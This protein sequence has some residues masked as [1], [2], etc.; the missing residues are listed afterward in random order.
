MNRVE[1]APD[2]GLSSEKS[3]D[4]LLSQLKHY[5]RQSERLQKVNSLY[6]RLAGVLDLPT[7]IET[8]SIWLAEHVAHE[9]IGYHNQTRQR[10]HLFCS[11]HGPERRHVIKVAEKLLKSSETSTGSTG[12]ID[13]LHTYQWDFESDEGSALLLLL[14]KNV[15]VPADDIELINESLSILAEP[16]KRTLDYEEIF[17][18]ARK[19]TLTGLPNR[20]VFEER[21]D[22]IIEQANRYNH[23]L[24]LAALDLDHFKDVNDTMGHLM[25]DEVLQQVAKSLKAQIRTSDLLVRMGGDEFLL[26]LPD[27][28]MA[29]ARNLG[30]RLCRAVEFLDIAAGQ[31]KLGIS[32]GMVQW[33]P[34]MSKGEWLEQADD[35]LYQ[36]KE[37]GRSQVAVH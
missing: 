34:G 8:Y 4:Q 14:R 30:E 7:I 37:N 13:S 20:L 26:I 22:G 36:A 17:E 12:V 3:M 11:S 1:Y 27:T 10:M 9:L 19:D 18:Q 31:A 21:V 24:T 16:L 33:Q 2:P 23:P 28:G 15:P 35:I 29:A 32:I 25:G 5:Q 6:Q